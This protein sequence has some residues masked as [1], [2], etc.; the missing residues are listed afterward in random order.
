MLLPFA[1][2]S[3]DTD[4]ILPA[5]STNKRLLADGAGRRLE[6]FFWRIWGSKDIVNTI[7]GQQVAVLF[8]AISE[9]GPL[10][11]TPTQS[12]RTS[13]NLGGYRRGPQ[14]LHS[15]LRPEGR[16]DSYSPETSQ[17]RKRQDDD[18]Q[19]SSF[20]VQ[21]GSEHSSRGEKDASS[22]AQP[23]DV[24]RFATIIEDDGDDRTPTATPPPTARRCKAAAD[25]T[26]IS[27]APDAT[28]RP[29]VNRTDS[30]TLPSGNFESPPRAESVTSEDTIKGDQER[31]KR[32]GRKRV[33]VH[34]HTPAS[35]R[36]PVV[37]R[38]KSSQSSSSTASNTASPRP[39]VTRV[40]EVDESVVSSQDDIIS[41]DL[42]EEELKPKEAPT[43]TAKTS[44]QRS[45]PPDHKSGKSS[46]GG[47]LVEPDFRS[48]F[49]AKARSA[50]SSF[51]SLP[52]L[53]Q[54]PS[55]TTAAFASYQA[56]GMTALAHQEQ[57]AERTKSRVTFSDEATSSGL[58]APTGPKAELDE[59]GQTLPRTQSQLT[60]L[61]ERD[62]RHPG[63]KGK[64]EKHEK[65][66]SR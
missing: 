27:G 16:L 35:R 11:T 19:R 12:P 42:P 53:I 54:S 57:S 9:E 2:T 63:G 65:K 48:K 52:S 41:M 45:P 56:S 8:H 55:T 51:V 23:A 47:V 14:P 28:S 10:R 40:S 6:N 32:G 39:S 20:I 59:G 26:C 17:I 21:R 7:T 1:F 36:R 33:A 3:S 37:M 13:R 31:A 64:A 43:T 50:Q 22:I 49:V 29:E 62:R 34:A 46:R 44:T 38:R 58:A 18:W 61:L 15:E 25:Y 66:S 5:Y 60:L 30:E 24:P 4:K